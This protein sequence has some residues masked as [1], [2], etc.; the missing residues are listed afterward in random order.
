MRVSII[1]TINGEKCVIR[2]LK[3]DE[4]PQELENL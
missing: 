2:I 3:K 1:P 4:K